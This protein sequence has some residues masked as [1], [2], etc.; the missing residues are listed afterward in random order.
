[1]NRETRL[2]DVFDLSDDWVTILHR[3]GI[4]TVCELFDRAKQLRTGAG[5]PLPIKQAVAFVLWDASCFCLPWAQCLRL[6]GMC[7]AATA[8]ELVTGGAA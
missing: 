5:E 3:W 1:M 7:K 8:A 6:Y 2:L 4:D